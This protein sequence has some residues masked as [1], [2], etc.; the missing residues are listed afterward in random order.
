MVVEAS[1][2]RD[3][4]PTPTVL[5]RRSV[6]MTA[7][8]R[9]APAFQPDRQVTTL[10]V[11][12]GRAHDRALPFAAW[13]S[14][15]WGVP[16]R[17]LHASGSIASE[18]DVLDGAVAEVGRFWPD[19]PVESEHL[20]GDDPA[21]A[22][23][24]AVGAHV[25]PV[26]ST[27]H[28]DGWS[29]KDSVAEALV[30]RIGVPVTL[31]GPE[32]KQPVVDGDVVVALDGTPVAEAALAAG[33]ALARSLGRQLW[34]VRVVAEPGPDAGDLHPEYGLGLQKLADGLDPEVS[35]RWEVI[36]SND[37]VNTVEGFADRVG[38]S[39]VVAATRGRTDETRTTM[40]SI[41]MGLV[42]VARRPVL[43]VH[44]DRVA[45]LSG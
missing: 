25:L 7:N 23:A 27:E 41:T 34:M 4:F 35:P 21:V 39:F 11:P 3:P 14:D 9:P 22:V 2:P 12:V 10:A 28:A 17:L 30:E 19:L 32:A 20:Y 31:V 8:T 6:D 15:T 40:C 42:S 29:F 44:A 24:D 36:H 43:V 38:A 45:E 13:L 18:D 26:L 33:A 37:P 16:V 5:D 1:A